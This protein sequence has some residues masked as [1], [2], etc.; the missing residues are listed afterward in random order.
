MAT[1]RE[2]QQ[3]Y[4]LRQ[5][6]AGKV[7]FKTHLDRGVLEAFRA[8]VKTRRSDVAA[9]LE[10]LMLG[11]AKESA[12]DI[13]RRERQAGRQSAAPAPVGGNAPP[14]SGERGQV[15]AAPAPVARQP[16]LEDALDV[17]PATRPVEKEPSPA[18]VGP[19]ARDLEPASR[20]WLP[21]GR[22]DDPDFEPPTGAELL[23]EELHPRELEVR[24]F[25]AADGGWTVTA[26]GRELGRAERR[27]VSEKPRAWRWFS[28]PARGAAPVA[29]HR[30]LA[31]A[32]ERLVAFA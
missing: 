15:G 2:R 9:V 14:S 10:W 3:A 27:S 7:A 32:V 19:G 23:R 5:R 11:Y 28:M 18:P 20:W 26:D 8:K 12:G 29:D 4:L 6:A 30:T 21:R 13:D 16:D 22:E 31:E 17:A 25:R 1:N 24:K